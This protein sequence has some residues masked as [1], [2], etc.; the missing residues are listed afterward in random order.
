[1]EFLNTYFQ[2]L[3]ANPVIIEL[4]FLG[5]LLLMIASIGIVV[6]AIV[7]MEADYFVAS[8]PSPASWRS[9]HPVL[10]ISIKAAKNLTGLGLLIVGLGLLVLPGQGLLTIIVGIGFLEFPGKR[11]IEQRMIRERHVKD[12]INWIRTKAG[13]PPILVSQ[14]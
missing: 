14:C 5:S 10:R 8:S 11:K 7:R 12:T 4:I 13:K 1:M 3:M 2:W 6:M 9:R